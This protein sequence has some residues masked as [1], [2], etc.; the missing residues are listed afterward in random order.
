M[1]LV[2]WYNLPYLTQFCLTS[3]EAIIA[4]GILLSLFSLIFRK[5]KPPYVGKVFYDI[6]KSGHQVRK[7]RHINV[8]VNRKA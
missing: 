4:F 8:I 6:E 7:D 1:L 3:L 2:I 5:Y